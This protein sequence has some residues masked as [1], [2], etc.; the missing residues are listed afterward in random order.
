MKK[1]YRKVL[2]SI[3]SI[4]SIFSTFIL[5]VYNIQTYKKEYDNIVKGL[6]F[7]DNRPIPNAFNN[8][9]IDNMMIMDYEVYTVKI[10][11]N[12]IERIIGHSSSVTNFDV[13]SIAN[14]IIGSNNTIMIGNLYSSKYVYNYKSSDTIVII[15]TES[16]SKKL[17]KVL[18]ESVVFFIGIEIFIYI[19]SLLISKWIIK[20]AEESFNK[21][22]DFI[23]DASHELKTPL[24]VIMASSDELKTDKKNSKYINNIK[25]ETDRMSK[26]IGGLLDLSRLEDGVSISTYKEENISKIIETIGLTFDAIAFEN[27]I[28]IN[29]NIEDNIMF[30]CSK[31]EI[32]KLL[33]IIIDNGIKHGN[34]NTK[35]DINLY[36]EKNNIIIEVINVGDPL[37]DNEKIFERFYRGDK[38]RNR[39]SNRYGLGLAIA[40]NIVINHGGNISAYSKD[41]KTT[42]KIIFKK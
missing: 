26:L 14:S 10:R 2:L 11:N 34:K 36:K 24:A 19:I 3:F 25:Y 1:L 39:E 8:N 30:K 23:A 5:F 35:L 15:N 20:P 29:L 31:D 18:I 7:R 27:N 41:G 33:S 21:Q 42:F 17:S 38:S 4:L 16:I 37:E 28:S 12:S 9:D 22:K 32:E 6:S 40:K 13:E